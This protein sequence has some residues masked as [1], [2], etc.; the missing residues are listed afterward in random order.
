MLPPPVRC[1]S[2]S[3]RIQSVAPAYVY[4]CPAPRQPLVLYPCFRTLNSF[5]LVT[6]PS[7]SATSTCSRVVSAVA[8]SVLSTAIHFSAHRPA[9]RAEKAELTAALVAALLIGVTRGV[10][11]MSGIPRRSRSQ[12]RPDLALLR[13]ALREPMLPAR[14]PAARL[15]GSLRRP[16]SLISH[17]CVS[18]SLNTPLPSPPIV[19]AHSPP[20]ISSIDTLKRISSTPRS[21]P[22]TPTDSSPVTWSWSQ[23]VGEYHPAS[24]DEP[25]ESVEEERRKKCQ[26][27]SPLFTLSNLFNADKS[28]KNPIVFCHGLLGFDSVTIG[29]PIAPLQVGYWRGIK[30][31]LEAN[32]TEV[33]ITRV[34]ATS[35]YVDRAK[36]LKEKISQTYTGRSVHLI[37]MLSQ[38]LVHRILTRISS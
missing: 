21:A 31:V 1:N 35:S 26:S 20:R 13:D 6:F 27:L 7:R 25:P 3:R 16:P 4:R 38:S 22:T 32:G 18:L 24:R 14:P 28:T 23:F 33:L 2:L 19:F 12:P 5:G 11:A 30:E 34:P 10:T 8:V 9:P 29:P 36:V 37:G 15:A 17:P